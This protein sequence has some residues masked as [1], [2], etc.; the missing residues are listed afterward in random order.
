MEARL[1][2]CPKEKNR[3]FTIKPVGFKDALE[4]TVHFAC[5]CDCEAT[6]Q[7]E[8]P[9]CN[10]GNGTYECGVCQCHPGRLGD[11]C[12]CADGDY[13]PSD[14][15]NCSPKAEDA[16]CNGRGNCVCGQCSCHTSGFGKVWG[17]YCECDDFNCLRF[18][19]EICSGEWIDTLLCLSRRQP[20][21]FQGDSH[22]GFFYHMF[23]S[24]LLINTSRQVVFVTFILSVCFRVGGFGRLMVLAG[25]SR[26]EEMS[27]SLEHVHNASVDLY[28]DLSLSLSTV[29]DGTLFSMF[30]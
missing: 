13:R 30:A 23:F 28:P 24:A 2:G 18:K 22:V 11:R 14:Q 27:I 17:K 7:P 29:K 10:Q 19:G 21:W 26:K 12:E 6:A 15:G 9:L 3:T 1:R 25:F 8:S 16:I 4:V 5:G 20:C